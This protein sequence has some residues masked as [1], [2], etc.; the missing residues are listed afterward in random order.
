MIINFIWIGLILIS[1]LAAL[2]GLLLGDTTVLPKLSTGMFDSA[3]SGFEFCLNLTGTLAFGL[4]L[5][6]I[7]E[8]SGL[9]DRIAQVI[10]PFLLKLF[11]E[12]PK[13]S[14]VSGHL[15]LNIS[16][17][18]LGLDNAATPIGLKA[19]EGMQE[20]NPQ[21][22]KASNAQIMFLTLNASGLTIIPLSI[23]AVRATAG[24][25]NPA[26]VFLPILIA[27]YCSTL[28]ALV[29]VCLIQRIN[30]L[31]PVLLFTL[32]GMTALVG[33][34]V[35]Y[36]AG[37]D[38]E[39]LQRVSSNASAFI[40]LSVVMVF[41]L[42]GM[43]K[44]INVYDAFI[45]GAKEGFESAIKII[46]YLVAMLIAIGLFRNS[47]VMDML[48]SGLGHVFAALGWN[49]E[50]IPALPTAI[51]KPLSGSGARAMFLEVMETKGPDSFPARLAGIFQGAADTT[52]FILT[53]YF[54][55]VK[56]KDSRYALY[57]C[58]LADLAG[59]LA[60][61]AVAFIFFK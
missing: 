34:I 2:V 30:L 31:Q 28:V 17:N 9:T 29:S 50:V 27:T 3:K 45:E 35:W 24:A 21:K 20:L 40:L 42:A 6:K 37:L 39:S 41:L 46:P 4:G 54:G 61:I 10:A 5:L 57:T 16:A 44:K 47:G 48:M 38:A 53:L 8:K 1:L 56:V 23:M 43:R 52:F 7:G 15:F 51:M 19:M 36:F 58:L 55:Y 26:D 60:A 59:V 18:M 11:P 14:P 32:L 22:E 25:A 49:Q 33:L 12:I 13:G